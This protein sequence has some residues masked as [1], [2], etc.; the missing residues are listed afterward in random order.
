ML[1]TDL[2][3]KQMQTPMKQPFGMPTDEMKTELIGKK[4]NVK[5]RLRKAGN[6]KSEPCVH[7]IK[8]LNEPLA[9]CQGK[10]FHMV[11]GRQMQGAR[12]FTE[13]WKRGELNGLDLYTLA[14]SLTNNHKFAA[15]CIRSKPTQSKRRKSFLTFEIQFKREVVLAVLFRGNS[16]TT[17]IMDQE[18]KEL[19]KSLKEHVRLSQQQAILAVNTRM[20]FLYWEIGH[21]INQQKEN[22]GWGAA[23][24]KQLS[25]DLSF[26]FPDIK[27]FSH[28]NLIYM[29]QFAEKQPI[30]ITQPLVAQLEK[31]AEKKNK[32]NNLV[33]A[34]PLAAQI[35]DSSHWTDFINT[36]IAK[37]TWSHHIILLD[38]TKSKD[39]Y[40][41]YLLRTISEGWS[42]RVLSNKI[43]QKLFESQGSLPNNFD[44]TLPD[45]Q[46]ELAKQT[47]KDHYIFDFLSLKDEALEK[48][49]EDSLLKQITKF[50][51]EM[52]KGF[53]FLGQ[54]HQLEVGGQDYYLDLLFFHTQ[55]NCYFIIELKIDDFK[56]EYAGKLNF[57]LN[58]A[59]DLLKQKQHQPT[60]GLL[61]CKSANKV[62]AEYSLKNNGKPIGVATYQLLP[63][64]EKLVELLS[65][66]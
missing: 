20:L 43:E 38:K 42:K 39:E 17:T 29:A 31:T 62:I 11:V 21:F 44:I 52:G 50:L 59:D 40:N 23:V 1:A 37:V 55:L 47:L 56:P 36:P 33:K 51:L 27:G 6:T 24:I 5:P 25:K 7:N 8:D 4:G 41:Y 49:V 54:Q 45:T 14:I 16:K 9:E 28:R 15:T 66:K 34:Q 3:P 65:K 64:E 35:Q 18:Y 32:T 61:L 10:R 46:S 57:Y 13:R 53:A 63:N 30:T 26:E 60:I 48:E 58:A 19:I 2:Q 22:L 12:N